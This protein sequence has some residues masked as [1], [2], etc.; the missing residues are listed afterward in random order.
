MSSTRIAALVRWVP[1]VTNV[2]VS[3]CR[4]SR[5]RQ[6]VTGCFAAGIY[7]RGLTF[8]QAEPNFLATSNIIM[9]GFLG[10]RGSLMLDLVVVSMTAIVPLMLTSVWL[11]RRKRQFATHKR[12][13]MMLALLLLLV[14]AAFEIEMRMFG[15]SDRAQSSPFWRDGRFNDPVDYSLALH[16]CFAIPTPLVWGTI[17]YRALRGFAKPVEPG[18]HS[19][20][21]RRWGKLGVAV[22][23]ATALT[24]WIFYYL[25]FAA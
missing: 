1:V 14:V 5:L 22:M 23:T 4:L 11:V 19:R 7:N 6:P 20:F 18:E 15:W 8:C 9:N 12:L 21:H 25:A 2:S 13:Q 24:G 10:T 16:L 17:I 3:L